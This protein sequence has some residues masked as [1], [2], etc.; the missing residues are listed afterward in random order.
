[1]GDI[2][3]V[4]VR[5]RLNKRFFSF[6]KV[7]GLWILSQTA[8][9][10][11]GPAVMWY[12]RCGQSASSFSR[13]V[14]RIVRARCWARAEFD[15]H[16]RHQASLSKEWLIPPLHSLPVMPPVGVSTVRNIKLDIQNS[17]EQKVSRNKTSETKPPPWQADQ[18]LLIT[19]KKAFIVTRIWPFLWHS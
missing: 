9:K 5:W 3:N 8:K 17:K 2:Y 18:I 11:K 16:V 10:K 13:R 15:E 7:S 12:V 6:L 1:M 4:L 14:E 19:G